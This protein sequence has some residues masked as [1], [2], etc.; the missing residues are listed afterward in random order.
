MTGTIIN[1]A[2]Q[3]HKAV[4]P[5]LLESVYDA[6]LAAE[7]R[8]QEID[9]LRQ[10][11]IP[12]FYRDIELLSG[13]R[14]DFLIFERVVVELK[15]VEIVLPVHKA[16]LLSYIRLANKPVG[17][18]INFNVAVLREGVSR[19]INPSHPDVRSL[20]SPQPD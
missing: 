5:G 11:E 14:L 6:C 13:L 8:H 17:L 4:G 1:A 9:F 19:I 15:A 16:Q 10:V 3:V 18:L 2:Y 20:A 7:L 12:I